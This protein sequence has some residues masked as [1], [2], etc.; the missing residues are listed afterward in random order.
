MA[1]YRGMSPD[2]LEAQYNLTARRGAEDFAALVER[3]LERSAI[4]RERSGARVDLAYGPGERERLDLFSGGD[5]DGP[6]LVYIH[7]GY[8]QRGDKGMY[9][10]VTEAF[11][12]H[13]VSVA[14]LNYTLTPAV[15]MGEIPPQIRRAI[16]WLWQNAADLG[17]SRERLHVMGHSAGGH[18]TAMM[19]A[20]DWPTFDAALPADLI[21]GG[22]PVSGVFDLEPIVHT[23]LNTGPRM[24]VEE[25]KAESPLFMPMFT[26]APQLVVDGGGETEEFH[27]QSDAYVER[28]ASD[29]RSVERYVVPDDDHF[30]EL[31][32]LAEEDSEL[33]ARSMRLIGGASA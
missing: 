28:V 2:E 19:M 18:L 21:K 7:G 8:W 24:S 22:I 29:A 25:A 1:V 13:G 20:T 10:F 6:L 27:R 17:Y 33:F 32:R 5:P 4:Q 30:D 12:R 23:T 11:V 31:H 15:R 9:G 16:R 14:M 26:D 3:W